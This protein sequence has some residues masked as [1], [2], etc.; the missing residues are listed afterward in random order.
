LPVSSKTLCDITDLIPFSGKAVLSPKMI[1]L[2]GGLLCQHEGSVSI[3]KSFG[4][5]YREDNEDHAMWN[6]ASCDT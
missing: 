4:T 5:L 6:S 3:D 2:F 1:G